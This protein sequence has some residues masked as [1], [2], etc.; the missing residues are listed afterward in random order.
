MIRSLVLTVSF[1]LSIAAPELAQTHPPDHAQGRPHDGSGHSS[2]DPSQHAAM[3]A[4]WLGSWT[5]T[6]SSPGEISR[7]LDLAVATD[8]L[9][10]V[11][12]KMKADQPI[13]VGAA[14]HVALDGSTLR[15]TQDV[16]GTPCQATAAVSAATPLVPETMKGTMACEHGEI[17]F[18]LK[19]TKR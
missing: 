17:A 10:N 6:S 7:K 4:L 18:E 9:G 5:G 14:S 19:K 2:L 12:L 8:K 3:H 13:R 15:W 1:C 16:S 11:T